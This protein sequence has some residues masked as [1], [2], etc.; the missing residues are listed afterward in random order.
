MPRGSSG[1]PGVRPVGFTRARITK[2]SV[3]LA[4][5]GIDAWTSSISSQSPLSGATRAKPDGL[6]GSSNPT[7][8][9]RG[10][11]GRS[12]RTGDVFAALKHATLNWVSVAL[13]TTRMGASLAA[14]GLE[15]NAVVSVGDVRPT[16][17]CAE[18]LTIQ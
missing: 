10:Q 12:T 16:I 3:T 1:R 5:P 8:V 7:P 11:P 18:T 15:T 13:H 17:T 14:D 9:A 6:P 2:S 4:C